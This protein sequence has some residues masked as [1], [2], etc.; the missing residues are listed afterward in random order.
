MI[1][2]LL[3]VVAQCREGHQLRAQVHEPADDVVDVELAS[4]AALQTVVDGQ[5]LESEGQSEQLDEGL[6]CQ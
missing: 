6:K 5:L 1:L 4:G 2:D 3:D